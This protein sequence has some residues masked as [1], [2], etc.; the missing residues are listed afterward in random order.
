MQH[1]YLAL[2]VQQL[3]FGLAWALAGRVWSEAAAFSR[4]W[5]GFCISSAL[6]LALTVGRLV[7]PPWLG[8]LTADVLL[9]LA[10]VLVWRA[11][12]RFFNL[13][14]SARLQSLVV[15]MTL[16]ALLAIGP[17]PD[18][19]AARTAL[20]LLLV[21][22]VILRSASRSH[23]PMA[24]EFG[25]RISWLVHLPGG[26]VALMMVVFAALVL[27]GPPE[28]WTLYH[29][30]QPGWLLGYALLVAS[31]GVHF[32]YGGML[33]TRMARRLLHLSHHDSLTG[34]LN[35]RAMHAVLAA[36]W[37]RHQRLQGGF[38]LLM[39]D[40]DHFKRVNDRFG[41]AVGDVALVTVARLMDQLLRPTDR[42]GRHGGEE[43]VILLPGIDATLGASVAERLR[44]A[45]VDTL[46]PVGEGTGL[47]LTV[48]IGV[49]SAAP[50][51]ASVEA[52]M[53]RA[54]QALYQAKSQGRNCVVLAAEPPPPPQG[55]PALRGLSAAAKAARADE[56]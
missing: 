5:L 54:D 11:V 6:G 38:T 30:E 14:P 41:H 55:P 20:L 46:V 2:A 22:G 10:F 18:R 42:A 26:A 49:A 47:Q 8:M 29:P 28:A 34:L 25:Q 33:V 4:L 3:L 40:L 35:R 52:V 13:V 37:Q 21:G 56:F 44:L 23:R 7:L 1:I 27:A 53:Q 9:V 12:E 19:T 31:F 51:D 48:S 32:A 17:S 45:L 36:E 50:G 15:V 16:L 39:L 24:H 43:F